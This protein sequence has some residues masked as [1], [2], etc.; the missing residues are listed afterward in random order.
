MDYEKRE[1]RQHIGELQELLMLRKKF[2]REET[3]KMQAGVVEIND[4]F[5]AIK[6]QVKLRELKHEGEVKALKAELEAA[7]YAYDA[8][9]G[10]SRHYQKRADEAEQKLTELHAWICDVLV[11]YSENKHAREWL[12]P[13][14]LHLDGESNTT[15]DPPRTPVK[16]GPEKWA[17]VSIIRNQDKYLCVWNTRYKGWSFP[18]GLRE[19]GEAIYQAQERELM[20]EAGLTCLKRELVFA[21]PTGLDHEP[22]RAGN[23][24]IYAVLAWKGEERSESEDRPIK[25]LT[26]DEFLRSSPFA[27]F[28]RDQVFPKY[29]AAMRARGFPPEAPYYDVHRAR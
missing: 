3:E 15:L 1:L 7:K 14:L 27:S 12:E 24:A 6:E 5:Q 26:R 18:G 9:L 21:G 17:A 16:K 29:D 22:S 28:Y 19:K 2:F 25:W 10:N 4:Q 8:Q 13:V 20:E 23:A 11:R